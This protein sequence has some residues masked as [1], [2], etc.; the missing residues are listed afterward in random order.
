MAQTEFY[1]IQ[2]VYSLTPTNDIYTY[3]M[4]MT[5]TQKRHDMFSF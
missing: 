3:D 4:D 2:A 5:M 1:P